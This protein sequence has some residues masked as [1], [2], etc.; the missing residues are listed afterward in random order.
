M[1]DEKQ[2]DALFDWV[3]DGAR[4]VADGRKIV[5]QICERLNSAG[6]PVDLYRLF[7]FTIHPLIKG[8]RLQW[9]AEKGTTISEAPF[10]LFETGEY[11]NN[12]LPFVIETRQ[13]LRRRLVDPDCP[14]DY[15]VVDELIADGFTDY[16]VQPVIYVDGE[17]NTMS[18]STKHEDG[19]SDAAIAALERIRPPLTRLIESYLLRLNAAFIISTY[20]G[21]GAGH[22]VLAGH[23]KRGDSEEI[24]AVILFA[25]FKNYTQLSNELPAGEV[26]E[27]LNRFFDALEE[28]IGTNGGEILK[29][30]GDGLLA[31]FPVDESD[32]QS[33]IKVASG[34]R[35]AIS[36]AHA[37]LAEGGNGDDFRAALHVGRL[38]YG[39]MGAAS[40]L[41]F[42]AI[43][44]A[45]NLTARLLG[46]A[47]AL[48][49]DDV[50][51]VEIARLLHSR[52]QNAIGN[53]ELK[54][55]KGKVPVFAIA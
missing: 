20:V 5:T 6:V 25:D 7:V 16:L 19:F 18:W 47:S 29:F 38:F 50:C 31:I 40:R 22:R 1:V 2:I 41:D 55:F 44:P 10:S 21:R 37:R 33:P 35:D 3:C 42:T 12:P 34:A 43:G 28:P 46:A 53:V 11:H 9:T 51:S 52:E 30:M 15:K 13:P 4:P 54:G 45:V 39:N 8:R 32:A 17:V 26:L 48:G 23:I 27:R 24:S 36:L 14:H 49:R